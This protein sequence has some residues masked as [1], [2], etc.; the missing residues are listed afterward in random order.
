MRTVQLALDDF[1][2]LT[3]GVYPQF[4]TSTT[5]DGRTVMDLCPLGDYP[6]NPYTHDPAVVRWNEDP[7]EPGEIGINPARADSYTVRGY[8][9]SGLLS[10]QMK[11]GD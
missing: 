8:G 3:G 7:R 11:P 10:L 5:P 2:S 1:A 6:V 9:E 4:P